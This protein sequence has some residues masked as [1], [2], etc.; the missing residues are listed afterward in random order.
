MSAKQDDNNNKKKKKVREDLMT[1]KRSVKRVETNSTLGRQQAKGIQHVVSYSELGRPIIKELPPIP[2]QPK[3]EKE[4]MKAKPEK[5]YK[6]NN[7]NNNNMNEMTVLKKPEIRVEKEVQKG[8]FVEQPIKRNTALPPKNKKMQAAE[9]V[10]PP[11]LILSY[12]LSSISFDPSTHIVISV[13]PR[14]TLLMREHYSA[15]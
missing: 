15:G 5:D 1:T 3:Q 13:R 2:K 6:Y 8:T 12:P 10:P 7:N 14:F 11:S 9:Q 4:I